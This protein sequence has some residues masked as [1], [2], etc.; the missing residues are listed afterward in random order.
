MQNHQAFDLIVFDWDGTLLD[1]AAAIVTAI[2]HACRDL[3]LPPPADATARQVI[4]L[5][6]A[7]ALTLAAPTLPAGQTQQ[8]VDRYRHHYLARDHELRLFPQVPTMLEQLTRAGKKLAVATGKSRV[9]L[10][11]ALRHS[12][13]G[14]YFLTERTVDECPSKPN[15]QMLLE[16]M[17]E[18]EVPPERTLMVGDTTHDLELAHNAHVAALAV[19]FGAH[20][21]AQLATHRPLAILDAPQDLLAWFFAER[22][23]D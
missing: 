4:G 18:C 9:G 13:T 19:A 2:Q 8:L 21:K 1:S 16:I 6:L 7:Q 3:G 11:R 22:S 23:A 10:D 5:G 12:G 17:D 14:R 15:P 20:P